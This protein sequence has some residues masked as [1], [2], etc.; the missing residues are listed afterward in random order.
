MLA[1]VLNAPL[2]HVSAFLILHELTAI[3]PLLGLT[4]AFHYGGWLGQAQ[5]MVESWVGDEKLKEGTDKMERWFRRRGWIK[6]GEVEG[7]TRGHARTTAGVVV[8]EWVSL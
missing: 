3:V 4:A 8:L 7:E 6:E 1:P 5:G 2:S